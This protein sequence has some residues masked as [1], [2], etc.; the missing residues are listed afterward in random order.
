MATVTRSL[1]LTCR[2]LLPATRSSTDR[3]SDAVRLRRHSLK[4]LPDVI[5]RCERCGEWRLSSASPPTRGASG[6]ARAGTGLSGGSVRP[7]GIAL[8]LA[9]MRAIKEIDTRA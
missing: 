4:A 2:Q 3:G 7:G 9:G 8:V 5:A 6:S 1:V